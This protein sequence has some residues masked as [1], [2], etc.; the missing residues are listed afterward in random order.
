[1]SLMVA[2]E[3]LSYGVTILG[4]PLAIAIFAQEQRKQ[5]QNEKSSLHRFLSEEY[6]RFLSV[7]LEHADLL[8]LQSRS[9]LH[10]T[11]EQEERKFIL[12]NILVSLFEKA[13]IILHS[14]DMSRDTQRL[15]LSWEDYMREWCRR[16]DFRKLLPRLLEGEDHEFS[17]HIQRI[18]NDEEQA[19]AGH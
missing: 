5:R 14:Q 7:L 2:L 13:Y 10:L 8:L 6:D 17:E 12:L 1:M 9:E 19:A 15:W 11:K 4:L 3:A 18:A 16:E